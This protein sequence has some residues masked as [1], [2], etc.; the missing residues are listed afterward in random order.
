MKIEVI[1]Q[2][3]EIFFKRFT[4]FKNNLFKNDPN[5]FNESVEDMKTYF[6]DNS[7]IIKNYHWKAYIISNNGKDLARGVISFHKGK[8][9]AQIGFL[10]F[11]QNIEAFKTMI[12]AMTEMAKENNIS[13]LRGPANINFFISYRWKL[14]N[15]GEPFYTEPLVPD[16]YHDFIKSIGFHVSETWDTFQLDYHV[17]LNRWKDKQKTITKKKTGNYQKLELRH[18]KPWNFDKEIEII[19]RL[20]VDSYKQMGEYEEID[21]E[22]FKLLYKDFKY[23]INPFFSYIAYYKNEPIGFVLNIFDSLHLLRQYAKKSPT[24]LEKVKLL[25]QLQLNRKRLLIMYS[26][27]VPTSE[28]EEVKGL[29]IKVSKRLIAMLLLFR[30][31]DVF[32]CFQSS[33]SPS[34][35]TFDDDA[36]KTYS[37]YAMY[38][39]SLN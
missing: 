21:L 1:S 9:I 30:V 3:D 38:R 28:G 15:G 10:E 29:Q 6:A 18:I 32:V 8:T 5:I 35:R 7:P 16:Y 31:K 13:E 2:W 37:Q 4:D 11:E 20:F 22:S 24:P 17:S 26:G 33:S 39:K 25:A 36:Q 12:E 34:K 19:H 23:L 27:R 14:P